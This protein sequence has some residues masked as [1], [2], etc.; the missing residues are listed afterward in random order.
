MASRASM[1]SSAINCIDY[2]DGVSIKS[3]ALK[4]WLR[5]RGI[6]QSEMAKVL[7]LPKQEFRRRLYKHCRFDQRRMT[8]LI[9]FMGARAA[10]EVIWFPTIQEKIKIRNYA[11]EGQMR[12]RDYIPDI[13]NTP[14][15]RKRRQIEEQMK[16]NGEDWEQTEEFEDYIFDTDELP[17]RRFLRRRGNG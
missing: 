3:Q 9:H 16:E 1:Y 6:T 13:Y 4:S 17:S 2:I 15:Q 11:M 12:E 5:R 7:E 8:K 14:A 10:I